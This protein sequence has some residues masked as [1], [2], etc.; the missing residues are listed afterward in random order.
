MNDFSNKLIEKYNPVSMYDYLEDNIMLNTK[1][2]KITKEEF[3]ELE[4]RLEKL[5]EL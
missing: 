4:K 1:D 5:R 3:N 2:F